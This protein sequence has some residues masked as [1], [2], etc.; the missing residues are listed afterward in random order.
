MAFFKPLNRP[1]T[2]WRGKSV[3]LVGASTGIGKACAEALHAA[4]AKVC[5]SA[6]QADKL[7]E[8]V[9]A[10][11]GSMALSVDVN[12]GAALRAAAQE[13]HAQ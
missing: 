3:W 1:I 7:L 12:H 2:D 9:N 5:V 6:R 8:F 13:V 11:P 4:G 10:H